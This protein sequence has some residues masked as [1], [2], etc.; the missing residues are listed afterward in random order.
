ML[1]L[2]VFLARGA[3]KCGYRRVPIWRGEQGSCVFM[4]QLDH[5]QIFWPQEKIRKLGL[6]FFLCEY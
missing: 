4:K 1:G 5:D 2:D 6:A 3:W